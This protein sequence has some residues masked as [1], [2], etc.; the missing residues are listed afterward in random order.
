MILILH[1]HF[2]KTPNAMKPATKRRLLIGTAVATLMIAVVCGYLITTFDW[3]RAKPWLHARVSDAT[4]RSFVI[5]GNLTVTWH[6][7]PSAEAGWR[8]RIPWPRLE[9]QDVSFGNPDWA[10]NTTNMADIKGMTFSINPLSL[11]S[12]TLVIPML[13]LDTPSVNLVRTMNGRNNWTFTPRDTS[14]WRLDLQDI[15]LDKGTVSLRDAARKLALVA[16]VDTLDNDSEYGVKWKLHGTFNRETVSGSGKAGAVLSLQNIATPYPLQ[17]NIHIGK[18][19]AAAAGT[20]TNPGKLAGLDMRLKLSGASLAHL[21]ALTGIVLPESPPYTTEGHL[22]GSFE[23]HNGAWTYEDFSGKVGSSDVSG[24]LEYQSERPRPLLKGAVVSK[25][26]KLADLAPLIGADSNASKANRGAP[27]TQPADKALPVQPFHTDRWASIDADVDFSATRVL[28]KTQLPVEHL[29]VKIL[30]Q[31]SV[32]TL[33]P[34]TMNIAGGMSDSNLIFDG[35]DRIIKARMKIAARHLKLKELFPNFQPMQ[36]SLGE[37]NG[38]AMLSATGNSVAAL[39]GSSNGEIKMLMNQGTVS[40]LLLEE[41]GMNIGNVIL[42]KLFGDRQVTLNCLAGDFTVTDGLMRDRVFVIDTE[43]AL[44]DIDGTIDLDHEKLNLVVKPGSK[45]LRVLS[46]RSPIYLTGTFKDP[47]VSVDKGVMA[48][49]AAGAIALAVAAPVA[50]LLPL[51][52]MGTREK[53]EC[54]AL[55]AAMSGKPVAPPPG[56]IYQGKPG[57]PTPVINPANSP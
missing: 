22:I 6:K 13:H 15:V 51:M 4:G 34:I 40:K 9:A 33:S 5:H 2:F 14:G 31:N 46:L 53:S 26:L 25:V 28:R 32:L 8:G 56:K 41:I 19:T 7:M 29:K 36:P 49:K 47:R 1:G 11:L 45:G 27:L 39:L 24:S 50:A 48:L 42:V 21:Y 43:D 55:L 10:A 16:D 17:A 3:N 20:L 38:D 37:I 52:N 30:L 18:T 54:T 44:L 12:K 57:K 23:L 35:H